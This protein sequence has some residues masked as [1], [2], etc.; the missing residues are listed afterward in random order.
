M[1]KAE[2]EWNAEM[3]RRRLDELIQAERALDA[4]KRGRTYKDHVFLTREDFSAVERSVSEL[5]DLA[6]GCNEARN[7]GKEE[8]LPSCAECPRQADIWGR[9]YSEGRASLSPRKLL[10]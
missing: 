3:D 9:A 10:S 4:L 2:E 6:R 7:A 5:R 1:A 8:W